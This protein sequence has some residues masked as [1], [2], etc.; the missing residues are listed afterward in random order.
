MKKVRKQKHEKLQKSAKTKVGK[1]N[2]QVNV[3]LWLIVNLNITTIIGIERIKR[4]S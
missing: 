3:D 1:Q 2:M 4:Y